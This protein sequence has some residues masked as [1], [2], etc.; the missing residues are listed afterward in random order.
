MVDCA[1]PAIG[2]TS[3][4]VAVGAPPADALGGSFEGR[5]AT[6]SPQSVR[7]AFRV[8]LILAPVLSGGVARAQEPPDV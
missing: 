7:L 1:P 2:L 5:F 3:I 4:H 8:L 6:V